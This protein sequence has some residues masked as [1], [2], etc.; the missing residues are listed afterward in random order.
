MF[1]PTG[2]I[3]M[4]FYFY[5]FWGFWLFDGYS[6]I[7]IIKI[8]TNE[9]MISCSWRCQRFISLLLR[10]FLTGCT[11]PSAALFCSSQF[12]LSTLSYHIKIKLIMFSC[13]AVSQLT[14]VLTPSGSDGSSLPL[15]W[16][17][18]LVASVWPWMYRRPY[19]RYVFNWLLVSGCF[20]LSQKKTKSDILNA[21]IS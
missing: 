21:N 5:R 19:I 7:L 16:Q 1:E 13:D 20:R 6:L 18:L 14:D 11:C 2:N 8:I 15:I 10:I 3:F 4:C 17:L 12:S 9:N